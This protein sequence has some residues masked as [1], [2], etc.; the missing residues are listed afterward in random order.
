MSAWRDDAACRGM[1]TTMFF[2]G[3]GD[4]TSVAAAKAVCSS[5]PVCDECATE[6]IL[7]ADADGIFGWLTPRERTHIRVRLGVE[8]RRPESAH[9]TPNRYSTYGCRCAVCCE[10]ENLRLQLQREK[11]PRSACAG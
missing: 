2:P 7:N 9:G 6:S 10:N 3:R 4:M 8:M 11:A 5:C 1:D